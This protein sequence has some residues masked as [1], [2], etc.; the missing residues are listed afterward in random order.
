MF[1]RP[2]IYI[3]LIYIVAAVPY[4]LLGLYAWRRRPAVAVTPFAWAMVG[5]SIWAFAY[6]LEIIFPYVPIKLFFVQI[7]YIGIVMAPV[8]MLFFAFEYT[9]NNHLLTRRNRI[10]FWTIPILT[11]I[12]VWT[13]GNHSLMW[14][15]R[16]LAENQG[17]LLLSLQYGPVFWV[18]T[19]Y[20]YTLVVVTAV[21]LIVELI[22]RPGIYRAQLS[23]VILS[24]ASP[25]IGSVIY[26]VGIGPVPNLD[27]ATLFF[28]PTALGLFWA[29]RKYRLLEVL[30]PEHISVIK[31][32]KDG[33]IVLNAQ[34]RMLYLN[35]TAEKLIKRNEHEVIGQPFAHVARKFHE[36]L[37]P[38][39]GAGEH[40]AEIKVIDGDQ[41]KV[42][43]ATVSPLQA[44]QT[45]GSQNGTDQM[46]ILHD[47]T[48]R[49]EVEFALSRRESIMSAISFAAER[50]LK[51]SAWE[52]NIPEVLE[53]LGQAADASRVF[54]VVNYTDDDRVI[55]SSLCYEWTAPGTEPQI[56]NPALQHVPLRKAGFGRWEKSLSNGEVIHGLVR[57]F[58][59]EERQF[60]KPLGSLSVVAIPIFAQTQW[61]GFLMFDES[62]AEREWTTTE[63]EA[64]HAAAGIFGSAETRARAEQKVIRRQHTLSL[65]HNI[66]EVSLQAEAVKDLAQVV[67]DRL[68]KLIDADGC[69]MTL[70]D[71]ENK[72]PVPIAAYG[73]P[74][75]IYATY[76]PK[77]G[78][79]TFTQSAL[80]LDRT[81]VV[82]DTAN[83]SYADPEIIHQFPAKSV[84]VLPLKAAKKNLGAVILAFNKHHEFK[85]EEIDISEQAAALIAL[86]LEK[87]QAVEEAKRRAETSETLRKAGLAIVE[88]LELD[89]TVSHILEHL[90]RVI[91]YDSASV[92]LLEEDGSQLKIIGGS[93]F[94]M[95]KEVLE[96]RFPIPGDNP[97]SIV[98]QTGRPHI[99]GDAPSKYPA[100]REKQNA[101]IRSWLG[102]PLIAQNKTIGL[103]A[104]DSKEPD[105]FTDKD[106]DLAAT[107]A[108]QVAIV[109]E[110]ARIHQETQTQAITDPLTGLYNRRGLYQLGEFEFQRSRRIDRP[111][112][113]MMLDIDRFKNVN[114]RY[115]H[116]TGDLVLHQLAQHCLKN[117][118]TTDLVGRYGGEE[119]V[120]LLTETNLEAA[121]MIAERLC[122]GIAIKPFQTEIGDLS[123]T[124][125]IGVS[126]A[127]H[128]DTLNT[129]IERAD[130]ALYQAK[131]SG[132]NRVFVC[133]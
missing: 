80:E 59:D 111:F 96:M 117:S 2:D 75:D 16:G 38:H 74:K 4:A 118:R 114:D 33:V 7:E 131:S 21:L 34:Q 54:V 44:L 125:S 26:V 50:F 87:F 90:N 110:N 41:L 32:M 15:V 93:G 84:L 79:V 113:A 122:L 72:V 13:S 23:F 11:L 22:Q 88:K 124:S 49:K 53:K 31:N 28:L 62:R 132:R 69:F 42:Y 97:N 37:L 64:F 133:E 109:L 106:A 116:A 126:E 104:I 8:Y 100:F 119:F 18:H 36:G 39:L 67:V 73:P 63:L 98:I 6:G 12:L 51:A 45:S 101:H 52:Q 108:S 86:A 17:L 3:P 65:L 1:A 40:R 48:R 107:Y 77:T 43:E 123:I 83:T 128:S 82:E 70:W 14:E 129:L 103:L 19:I 81:L 120:I 91:T 46:V 25:F 57:N 68:G 130:A 27:L 85:K 60:F 127:K 10:L 102:V 30:P 121:R 95:L 35:P 24:I 55:H 112:S 76:K 89:Q 29:I 20:S 115:G 56:R 105:R 9:G 78:E 94:Q 58:P 5:M 61:W 71:E 47:V 92:Q 99:I 66:V